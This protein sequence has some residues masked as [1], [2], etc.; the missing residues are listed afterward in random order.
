MSKANFKFGLVNL[1]N[2]MCEHVIPNVV[3]LQRAL[4]PL[5]FVVVHKALKYRALIPTT[6]CSCSSN[7]V[8]YNISQ[9]LYVQIDKDKFS[10]RLLKPEY[11]NIYLQW[12]SIISLC[13]LTKLKISAASLELA[14][15]F[16]FV[17]YA[18]NNNSM[19]FITV[20]NAL[21]S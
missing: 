7:Y 15:S 19:H 18:T 13:V 10:E 8:R 16:S 12:S 4:A 5:K 11:L 21:F 9:V 2:F 14:T 3:H 1:H 6:S 17:K 20:G